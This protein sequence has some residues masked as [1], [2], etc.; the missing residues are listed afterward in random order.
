MLLW[1]DNH[2]LMRKYS[3]LLAIACIFFIAVVSCSNH[4]IVI[5]KRCI[6]KM[7]DY[8]DTSFIG[9]IRCLQYHDG[10][11]FL[12]DINR[13]SVLIMNDD[14]SSFQ[15]VSM[16]G[17]GPGELLDPFSFTVSGDS[18]Y[19]MDFG[20]NAMKT[21]VGGRFIGEK[22][23]PF[24]IRD[25]RFVK[26]G[27][28]FYFPYRDPKASVIS[29]S[30]EGP[31]SVFLE[32]E[33]H[34]NDAKTVT[35]N[36]CNVLA[37]RENLIIIP[38]ALPWVKIVGKDGKVLRTLDLAQSALYKRNVAF[39]HRADKEDKS[40]YVLNRDACVVGEDLLILIPCYD[41]GYEC[42]R[43]ISVDLNSG[44]QTKEMMLLQGTDYTSFCSDG[45]RLYVFNGS[46]NQIE[47]YEL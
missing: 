33:R 32:S 11:L 41:E 24:M 21:F 10:Q 38:D 40:C 35:M 19:V 34:S 7:S 25:Q 6:L 46:E 14:F 31:H 13:R 28:V 18:I 2:P 23:F 29:T 5:Q 9:D 27:G 17:R 39:A 12:L 8:P 15:S 47:V 30:L 37:Y 16:G 45:A 26:S 4:E 36:S 43:I 42:N 20:P 44:H 1:T 3:Y 22:S